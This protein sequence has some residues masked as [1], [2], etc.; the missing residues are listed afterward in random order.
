MGYPAVMLSDG[1]KRTTVAVVALALALVGAAAP[2]AGEE[3]RLV[4][5]APGYPGTTEQAIPTMDAFARQVETASG[6]P[7]GSVTAAYHEIEAAGVEA[8]RDADLIVATLPFFLAHRRSLDL[9]PVLA[10]ATVGIGANETWSLVAPR[11]RVSSPDDLAGWELASIAGYAPAFVRGPALAEWGELPR[12]VD[13]RPTVRVLSD[14]RRAAR[15]ERVAVLL[16]GAQAVALDRLPFADAL[17]VVA[18]SR[19][20]PASLVCSRGPVPPGGALARVIEGLGRMQATEAG[21]EALASIRLDAFVPVSDAE[22]L[23]ALGRNL[24]AAGTAP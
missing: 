9:R 3:T 20:M 2:L 10:V 5:C 12:S 6:E 15:G 19:P 24:D 14:L 11:G 16:D 4:F 13:V 22:A 23:D 21:R 1:R 8:A 7:I 18:R 17:E